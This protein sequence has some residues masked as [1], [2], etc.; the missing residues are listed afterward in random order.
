[1]KTIRH[2]VCEG[3]GRGLVLGYH[4]HWSDLQDHLELK[5][6][7]MGHLEPVLLQKIIHVI[8][9]QRF[10]GKLLAQT[11]REIEAGGL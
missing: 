8:L 3:D 7:V 2:L 5:N 6:A 11:M 9:S 10:T 4:T 1:M